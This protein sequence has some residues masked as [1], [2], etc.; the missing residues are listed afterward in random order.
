MSTN[1]FFRFGW[2]IAGF[3]ALA[4]IILAMMP[5]TTIFSFT[6]KQ[7]GKV[8]VLFW[9]LIPPIYFWFDW[10]SSASRHNK[11]DRVSLSR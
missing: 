4:S 8:I 10:N 1:S 2:L 7:F 9:V 6:P 3:A 5:A 11:N